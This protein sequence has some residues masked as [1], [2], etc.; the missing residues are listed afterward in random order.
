[1]AQGNSLDRIRENV[2]NYVGEKVRLKANKGRKKTTIREGVLESV[3]PNIFVV[4]ID[5][6]YNSIRRVSYSYSDI[7]TETVEVTVY[8]EGE[9]IRIS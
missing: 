3:Y 2:K 1:M 9:Q 4:K 6:G 7:L 8:D 5:G